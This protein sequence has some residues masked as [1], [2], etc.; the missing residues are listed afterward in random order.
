MFDSQ[1]VINNKFATVHRNKMTVEFTFYGIPFN[2][3]LV[4]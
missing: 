3:L 1:L 4:A 2:E